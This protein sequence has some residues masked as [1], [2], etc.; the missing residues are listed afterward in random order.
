MNCLVADLPLRE[1]TT[2][3]QFCGQ[4][5]K[6]RTWTNAGQGVF[7]IKHANSKLKHPPS[8][9]LGFNSILEIKKNLPRQ[10]EVDFF[11]TD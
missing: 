10:N 4:M 5:M 1:S 7:L 6:K 11:I 3:I 9:F 8:V 2:N